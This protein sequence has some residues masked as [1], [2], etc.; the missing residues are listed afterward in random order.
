MFGVQGYSCY[1]HPC[2]PVVRPGTGA[3]K[4]NTNV[5]A[6][7]ALSAAVGLG[8]MIAMTYLLQMNRMPA[9]SL[10]HVT[11]APLAVVFT[12]QLSHIGNGKFKYGAGTANGSICLP[13][14]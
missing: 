11:H 14:M 12:L 2:Q 3:A 8:V 7:I 5:V 4:L 10:S 1:C 6:A 9:V 13:P